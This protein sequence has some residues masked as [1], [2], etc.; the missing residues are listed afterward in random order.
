MNVMKRR[1]RWIWGLVVV[2]ILGLL[3]FIMVMRTQLGYA[4]Q[5]VRFFPTL[6]QE[7]DTIPLVKVQGRLVLVNGCIRVRSLLPTYG[8]LFGSNSLV[9]WPNGYS[10]ETQG[11]RIV[12]LDAGGGVVARVGDVIKGGGGVSHNREGVEASIEQLIPQECRGPY[13]ALWIER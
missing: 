3:T 5:E 4:N 12:V 10:T 9:I 11:K 2:C 1:S 7:S 6:R 13:T 8:L